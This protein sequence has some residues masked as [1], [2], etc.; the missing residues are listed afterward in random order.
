MFIFL[1]YAHGVSPSVFGGD[2]G[3]IILSAWFGSIAHAPGYPLNSTIGWVFT[4]LPFEGTIA[5]KA[6]LMAAFIQASVVLLVFLT[7]KKIIN[8]TLVSLATAFTLGFTS[9]FWLY[10]HVI[11]VFQINTLLISASVFNLICWRQKELKGKRS[12]HLFYLSICFLSLAIFHHQTSVLFAPAYV[13]LVFKTKKDIFKRKRVLLNSLFAFAVGLIPLLYLP[14]AATMDAPTNWG[15]AT[16]ITT[17]LRIIT[18]GEYGTFVAAG[19]LIGLDF[20]SRLAELANYLLFLKADFKMLGV[21]LI[22][23]GGVYLFVKDRT[24]FWFFSIA[25]FFTGPF[26]LFYSSFPFFNDF[27]AGLWERFLLLSYFFNVFFISY[28]YLA[29][30]SILKTFFKRFK[31]SRQRELKV[32]L[33]LFSLIILILPVHLFAVNNYKTDSSSFRLGD[34]LGSD[35]LASAEDRGII[36]LLGDTQ[37]FNT[38]YVYYTSKKYWDI[39]IIRGGSLSDIDYRSKL[40]RLYPD[41]IFPSDFLDNSKLQGEYYIRNLIEKNREMFPIY[42]YSSPVIIDNYRWMQTGLLKKLIRIDEYSSA[43]LVKIN[44]DLFSNFAFNDFNSD[45]QYEQFMTAHI[46]ESYYGS[47]MQLAV[48]LIDNNSNDLAAY[49]LNRAKMLMPDRKDAYAVLGNELFLKKYCDEAL[50]NFEKVYELDQKEWKAL[51]AIGNVYGDCVGDQ[52]KSLMYKAR[53]KDLRVEIE[54]F[55]LE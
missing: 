24:T 32:P 37:T 21:L 10:A 5:Y 18:R 46:K 2:S 36:F 25:V 33:L 6:N 13:Y 45:G 22:F 17:F 11:E 39:K 41:L 42:F 30:Y 26:F 51:E 20:V 40:T 15:D 48:E 53:A 50:K 47:I 35:I 14:I 7:V 44:G 28:G 34:W 55:S 3:D 54:G 43:E 8:N 4:H 52:Q 16:K 38:E 49:Y 1:V 19:S 9:L 12:F 29:F 27:Y 31:F 23:L